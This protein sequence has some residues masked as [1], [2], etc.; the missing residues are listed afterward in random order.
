MLFVRT[1]LIFFAWICSLSISAFAGQS[2]L[3]DLAELQWTI[4]VRS[5]EKLIE[6]AKGS[7]WA[8]MKNWKT[9]YYDTDKFN[10][11]RDHDIILRERIQK[12]DFATDLKLKMDARAYHRSQDAG[13]LQNYKCEY[14]V[15]PGG[16]RIGC[17]LR[18]K[19]HHPKERFNEQQL[20]DLERLTNFQL[21][22]LRSFGPVPTTEIEFNLDHMDEAVAV[23]VT[24][25]KSQQNW[26]EVSVRSR[27]DKV[28]AARQTVQRWLTDNSIQT[29][30]P[31]SSKTEAILKA[32]RDNR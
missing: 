13:F 11:L 32:Y 6:V 10:L 24:Q 9:V 22:D 14:D 28:T 4:C 17:K 30:Q 15:Y 23:E 16:R 3:P 18:H 5:H 29:C 20:Q 8:E 27:V 21:H 12:S 7:K 31:N 2:G 1:I 26:A 19:S 25:I